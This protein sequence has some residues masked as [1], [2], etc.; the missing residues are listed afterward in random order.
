[1]L[2]SIL[3]NPFVIGNEHPSV[4]GAGDKDL[5]SFNNHAESAMPRIAFGSNSP[6][7]LAFER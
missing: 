6:M 2:F 7:A 4:T 5:S 3:G 1:M